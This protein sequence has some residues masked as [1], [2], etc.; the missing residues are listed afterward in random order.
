MLIGAHLSSSLVLYGKSVLSLQ[1]D[2]TKRLVLLLS[3]GKIHQLNFFKTSELLHEPP[4]L[5]FIIYAFCP[6]YIYVFC[7][8]LRTNSD[9][10]SIQ[11]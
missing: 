4:A 5:T 11:H 1:Y 10:F 9:Y 7:V 3:G 2:S 8:D 6:Q